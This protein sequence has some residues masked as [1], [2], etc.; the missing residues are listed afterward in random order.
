LNVS[1]FHE[2]LFQM[3]LVIDSIY[4]FNLIPNKL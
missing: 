4:N 1:Q 3:T 2:V